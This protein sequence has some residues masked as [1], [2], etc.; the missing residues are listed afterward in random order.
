[1]A[2]IATET[3]IAAGA[4]NSLTGQLIQ[5][6][7]DHSCEIPTRG[8]WHASFMHLTL[9]V[10]DVAGIDRRGLHLH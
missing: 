6:A 3:E 1:V 8:S 4:E 7:S 9:H 10:F 2:A 5:A